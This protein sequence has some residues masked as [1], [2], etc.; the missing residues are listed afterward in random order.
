M[1]FR[2]HLISYQLY[3]HLNYI[4]P[5]LV[6]TG[7]RCLSIRQPSC[8]QYI[9]NDSRSSSYISPSSPC[10]CFS[11]L[12]SYKVR[13]APLRYI[14]HAM[15]IYSG[16][17]ECKKCSSCADAPSAMRVMMHQRQHRYKN[18]KSWFTRSGFGWY[19]GRV[20]PSSR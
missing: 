9:K 14:V 20:L 8:P 12:W 7:F 1:N 3:K 17:K 10:F 5:C 11:I 2:F 19:D 6:Q 13:P 16:T 15:A 18:E 4:S